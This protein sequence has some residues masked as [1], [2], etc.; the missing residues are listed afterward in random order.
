MR[1]HFA[2]LGHGCGGNRVLV[3]DPRGSAVQ[4]HKRCQRLA[5]QMVHTGPERRDS[6]LFFGL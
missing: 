2:G 1:S 3:S 6:Q 4:V 5:T